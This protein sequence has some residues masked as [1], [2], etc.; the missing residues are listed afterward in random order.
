M[1]VISSRIHA[2][3]IH[4]E[5]LHHVS[6]KVVHITFIYGSNDGDERESLWD[7]LRQLASFTIDWIIMGDFNIVKEMEERLGPNPPSLAE[8]LAFNK[9]LLDCNLDDLQ[10]YGSDYTW[11]N[12]RDGDARIWS[13]LDRVLTNPN[14]LIKYPHTQVTILP[15]GISDHSPLLV[16]IKE[17]YQ[18]KKSFSYLN[19]WEEHQDYHTLVYQAWQLPVK[20]NAMFK[21]FARLKNV[22]RNLVDLH[23]RNF[24]DIS[25][26]V[27]LAKKDLETC[28]K[29]IQQNPL[30]PS[31]LA[32]EKVI[33]ED[34]WNLR[35]M[36]RSS[37]MQRS[38]VQDIKYND[39]P[40][41]YFFARIAARKHQSI[42]GRIMDK[43]GTVREGIQDV[44]QAFVEYYKWLLGEKVDTV[45][46]PTLLDG[47]T[48]EESD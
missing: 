32:Q 37:L 43:E 41:S 10:G 28:Q 21:L 8:V 45:T 33:L 17:T 30:D 14:W 18:F 3:L 4:V 34:Y 22:R 44:N 38:K 19:C 9:C 5:L 26:K 13:K 24:L 12:K 48:I 16:Q 35:R 23:K 46:L 1:T 31:Y 40:T 42:I 20:G 7:E 6:Q 29:H 25:L 2:Q 39:A 15:A 47:P 11:T 36:E 27:R